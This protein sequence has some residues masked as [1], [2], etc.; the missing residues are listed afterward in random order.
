MDD[1]PPQNACDTVVEAK[2]LEEFGSGL[3][4]AAAA[5]SMFNG[6]CCTALVVISAISVSLHWYGTPLNVTVNVPLASGAPGSVVVTPQSLSALT[7]FIAFPAVLP[8]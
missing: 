3:V 8:S 5:A 4:V 6:H 7:S 1:V 2:L